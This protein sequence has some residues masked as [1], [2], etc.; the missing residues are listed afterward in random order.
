[1]TIAIYRSAYLLKNQLTPHKV[2]CIVF[3]IEIV[4]KEFT[5]CGG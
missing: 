5:V 1:M 2:S 4:V 3:D